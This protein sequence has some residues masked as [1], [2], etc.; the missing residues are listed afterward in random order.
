MIDFQNVCKHYSGKDILNAVSFQIHPGERVGIVGPNGAGKST[1]FALICGEISPDHGEVVLPKNMRVSHLRQQIRSDDDDIRSILEHAEDAIPELKVI[2]REL[3][4]LEHGM[5]PLE[6]EQRAQTL[7]RVGHLQTQFEH[8]GGYRLKT[9]AAAILCGLGFKAASLSNPFS[10][11]SGGWQM[12]AELARAL[13]ARPDALLLDEPTN[14]LDLPAVEWLVDYLRSFPGTLALISHDRYILNALTTVTIELNNG[15]ATR[16][17][18]NYDRYAAERRARAEQMVAAA[19]N[20]EKHRQHLESFVERFK[21]KASKASQAQSRVRQLEKMEIIEIPED[22]LSP[23]KIRLKNPPHCGAEILRL[24]AAGVAYGDGPWIFKDLDLSIENG[25]K[26]A[27]VG[28]NGLGKT[29]LL[30]A[31]SGQLPLK[32]GRRVMGHNA[33][34]GYLSQDFRDV[35]KP[36]ATVLRTIL[37]HAPELGEKGARPLLGSFRFSGQAVEKTVQ[38]LSG[39]EK[40]RL[41]LARLLANPPNLL[42]LDEPTTHLDI[43]SRE[44]LENALAGFTGSIC[45]VSHDIAF[46]RKVATTILSLTPGRLTRFHGDYNY[47]LAKRAELEPTQSDTPALQEART[48]DLRKDRRRQEAVLRQNLSKKRRNIEKTI[49]KTEERIGALESEKEGILSLLATG[50][51][52]DHHAVG[53]RLKNIDDE[54]KTVMPEWEAASTQL[55]LLIAD[56]DRLIQS[57]PN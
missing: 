53:V 27:V 38:V 45:L 47:Y 34:I 28:Q 30:R 3:E 15:N 50:S 25:M 31:L 16:Y 13:V 55:D 44:A 23:P 41:G 7:E 12:R 49:N 33:R 2:Q 11:F 24:E 46:V 20:Q 21:A 48:L 35:M 19:K 36:D 32:A 14:Y 37:D 18:G 17:I 9:D 57:I 54:L 42:L 40:M 4:L 8:L 5:E 6:G 29:T 56:F 10:S 39:G 52:V 22:F 26:M 51:S 1:V 43:G